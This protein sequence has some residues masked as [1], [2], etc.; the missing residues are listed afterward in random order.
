M[1]PMPKAIPC[2]ARSIKA[3]VSFAFTK[4]IY[5]DSVWL[6]IK[7]PNLEAKNLQR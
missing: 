7:K 3:A 2:N 4:A 1:N 6:Q 5:A